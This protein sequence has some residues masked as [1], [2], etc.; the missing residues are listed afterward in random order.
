MV[1]AF[2]YWKQLE[3]LRLLNCPSSLK[4]LVKLDHIIL[5]AALSELS[6][7][8][9]DWSKLITWSCIFKL[10]FASKVQLLAELKELHKSPDNKVLQKLLTNLRTVRPYMDVYNIAVLLLLDETGPTACQ[11]WDLT[12]DSEN[13]LFD[14]VQRLQSL[15]YDEAQIVISDWKIVGNL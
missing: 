1:L 14:R 12:K 2:R 11:H 5:F 3:M 15:Q 13:Q 6:F 9:M 8:K 4:T 7:I 10:N